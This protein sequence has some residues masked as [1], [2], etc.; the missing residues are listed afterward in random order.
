MAEGSIKRLIIELPP[1]HGKSELVSVHFPPWYLA[2]HPDH[3]IIACCYGWDLVRSFSKRCLDDLN[4]PE[5]A[6]MYP[7]IMLDPRQS[8]LQRWGLRGRRGSYL[9]T[10]I[11]G[12]I[13]G[14]GANVL[15]IDDP[16]KL[17]KDVESDRYRED[18]WVWY[19]ANARTR[20]EPNGSI[21]LC[22]TRWHEDDL[23]GRILEDAEQGG[24]QWH[25][26]RLPALAEEDDPLGRRYR[27]PL[28]PDRY[29]E[30]ML[31]T[32]E[33]T[34]PA[35]EWESQY[36][37]NPFP[38]GGEVFSRDHWATFEAG[39][40]VQLTKVVTSWDTALKDEERNDFT[41]VWTAGLGTNGYVYVFDVQKIRATAA[42]LIG[43][44]QQ[45]GLIVAYVAWLSKNGIMPSE[46]LIEDAGSGTAAI[47]L[48]A[49]SAPW[50]P[51]VPVKT[52][53]RSKVERAR[54]VVPF[55][56]AR[57]VLHRRDANWRNWF[58]PMCQ[59]FP[60][61]K[62][63][64]PVDAMTQGLWKLMLPPASY[65]AAMAPEDMP[66]VSLGRY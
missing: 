8:G 53:N 55:Y 60:G 64:D 15:I 50:L 62:V 10:S 45:P 54:A 2:E 49:A 48:L 4:N 22:L 34:M 5:F 1:R 29:T 32:L 58:E 35:Y 26:L 39:T 61:T 25:I 38:P 41:G 17:R 42:Q 57:R 65:T 66:R 18:Q 44:Q 37:Q 47:Q 9:A 31:E 20:L 21:I 59:A 23:A 40:P 43:T 63:K 30:E 14:S 36:Q 51:I 46:V 27:E 19:K 56:E 11:G 28:W 33:Q 12:P 16:V 24:E 13:T 7:H 6:R 52:G 3:Q